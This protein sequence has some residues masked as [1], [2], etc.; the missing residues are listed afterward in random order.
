MDESLVCH[1]CDSDCGRNTATPRLR[2]RLPSPAPT[3]CSHTRFSRSIGVALWCVNKKHTKPKV[4]TR[5]GTG[6]SFRKKFFTLRWGINI[7]L[8]V[9]TT[10]TATPRSH[11][12]TTTPIS[13]PADGRRGGK[14]TSWWKILSVRAGGLGARSCLSQPHHV[15]FTLTRH[16]SHPTHLLQP[17]LQIDI[18]PP[19]FGPGDHHLHPPLNQTPD[20]LSLQHP[21]GHPKQSQDHHFRQHRAQQLNPKATEGKRS[22]L[23]HPIERFQ[24]SD[25][26]G[27]KSEALGGQHT[28]SARE[29]ANPPLEKQ[30]Q[31]P[32]E[33]PLQ[34]HQQECGHQAWVPRALQPEE[35]H[36]RRQEA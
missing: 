19:S 34:K 7:Q 25:S 23:Q 12:P 28:K 24:D 26:H 18:H 4:N 11:P 27:D 13:S 32:V 9:R 20:L 1:D 5:R 2:L 31:V 17:K 33:D 3:Q 30:G 14:E 36:G 10:A 8:C 35:D 29:N 21:L 6:S 22:R 15:P 16:D